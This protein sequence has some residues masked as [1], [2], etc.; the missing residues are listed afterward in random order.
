M[1]P[2]KN[3]A[4]KELKSSKCQV[5]PILPAPFGIASLFLD[6]SQSLSTETWMLPLWQHFVTDCIESWSQVDWHK[7]FNMTFSFQCPQK[8]NTVKS[9]PTE[10]NAIRLDDNLRDIDW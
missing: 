2:L 9:S 6:S 1:F 5:D 10:R 8:G 3:L 7:L 4:R